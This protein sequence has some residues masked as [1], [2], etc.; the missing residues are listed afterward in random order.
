MCREPSI[1]DYGECDV[2][3]VDHGECDASLYNAFRKTCWC[4]ICCDVY[5]QG[6]RPARFES[7]C[8]QVESPRKVLISSFCHQ[9]ITVHEFAFEHFLLLVIGRCASQQRI[10]MAVRIQAP[11]VEWALRARS[12][13]SISVQD[14]AMLRASNHLLLPAADSRAMRPQPSTR[15]APRAVHSCER[16]RDRCA[17]RA[18]CAAALVQGGSGGRLP[19]PQPSLP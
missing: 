14:S 16:S 6:G 17:P 11:R 1:I 19:A 13:R 18:S 2:P 9:S 8:T 7:R 12:T 3:M 15:S 10:D 4:I 5:T